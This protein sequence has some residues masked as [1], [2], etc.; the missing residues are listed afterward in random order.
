M[1]AS[2][3][4]ARNGVHLE[5]DDLAIKRAEDGL[6]RSYPTQRARA[7]A[8]RFWPREPAD[9]IGHD[10]GNDLGRRPARLFYRRDIEFALL[11]FFY[12]EV[13]ET[14]SHRFKEAV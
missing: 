13:L 1:A 8:H 12:C 7:P 3:I 4:A 14:E 10:L 2:S 9:D 5:G 11:V 6:E